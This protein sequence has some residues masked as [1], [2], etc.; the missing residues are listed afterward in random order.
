[1]LEINDIVLYCVVSYCIVG[2]LY[3]RLIV[4]YCI[5]LYCIVL[6][7]IVL[8]CIV[9]YCIVILSKD[10]NIDFQTKLVGSTTMLHIIVSRVYIP[11]RYVRLTVEVFVQ[12]PS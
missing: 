4:L 11:G 3:C 7:C 8:Y 6:Y 9:L 12:E 2:L 1:M 10:L 5:V